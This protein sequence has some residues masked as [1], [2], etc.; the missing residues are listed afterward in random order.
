MTSEWTYVLDLRGPPT[1]GSWVDWV[2]ETGG[3][4]S[5]VLSFP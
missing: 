4:Y 3:D 5:L 1:F 2:V